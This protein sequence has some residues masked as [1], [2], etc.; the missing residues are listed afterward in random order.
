MRDA[1]LQLGIVAPVTVIRVTV[2]RVSAAEIVIQ[3]R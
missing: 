3:L 1:S 2:I